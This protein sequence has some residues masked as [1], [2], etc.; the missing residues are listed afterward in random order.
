[1]GTQTDETAS[2]D[3]VAIVTG[4]SRGIGRDIAHELASSGYSVVVVY[5]RDRSEAEATVDAILAANGTALTVRADVDDELDVK[6]VFDETAA[7]FGGVDVVVHTATRG[8]A[9]VSRHAARR[10]RRG[11][12]IVN[13][14]GCEA[15]PP[16]L[17]DEL[18]AR[19]IMVDCLAPG[20]EPPGADHPVPDVVALLDRWRGRP[21]R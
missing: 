7:A 6:R 12:A 1:V 9:V 3:R 18:R 20:L 13:V 16:V 15:I 17:A 10:L 2:G 5:L 19:D 14:S 21:G 11:G 8:L 4:G